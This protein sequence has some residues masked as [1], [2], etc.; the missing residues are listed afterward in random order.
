[1]RNHHIDLSETPIQTTIPRPYTL[2][3]EEQA[4]ARTEIQRTF[5]K[6][7][8]LEVDHI[9][10]EYVSNIFPGKKDSAKLRMIL[11]VKKL[12]GHI[13]HAHFKMNTLKTALQL[14]EQG[15][16][17]ISIDFSDAY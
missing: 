9:E 14:V 16:W 3:D 11:N 17:F 7:V 12:N 10:G 13:D 2:S 8:I 15:D 6:G 4:F 1:M 5:D